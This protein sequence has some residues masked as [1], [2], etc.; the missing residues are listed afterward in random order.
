M[1]K[2]KD[3]AME[4][5]QIN[6]IF[7]E[8]LNQTISN[9]AEK[10]RLDVTHMLLHICGQIRPYMV[11]TEAG[12]EALSEEIFSNEIRRDFIFN[13][14]FNFLSR[15]YFIDDKLITKIISGFTHS[16]A[17]TERVNSS[18]SG[19][20]ALDKLPEELS[21]RIPTH[22]EIYNLLCS[23]KWLIIVLLIN[24]YISVEDFQ[25]EEKTS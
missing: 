13:L 6:T 18:S 5:N 19:Y 21:N 8:A 3:K 14:T 16:L 12:S 10:A 4:Q 22:E 2:Q 20:E 23:N 11:V 24:L 17:L 7:K 15:I 9:Y 1:I 25:L